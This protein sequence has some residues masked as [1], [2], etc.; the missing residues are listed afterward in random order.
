M[1]PS[2]FNTFVRRLSVYIAGQC[3]MATEELMPKTSKAKIKRPRELKAKDLDYSVD[4][5][6]TGVTST[7]DVDP[8]CTIIG[9][10]RAIDAIKT[11]LNVKSDGYNIFVT[12]LVGTGRTT[13]IKHLLEQ[14]D[15]KQPK[16]Q[17]VCYVN[18]FKN[19]DSPK[20]LTFPAGDGRRF[21]KDMSYL[22]S[23]VRKAVPKIFMSDDYK[24][25][26]SRIVRE[27]EGRQ[28]DLIRG[29][30]EKLNQA[31]F[32]MVQVQSGMGIRNEIQPLIDE[33]PASLDKLE[34]LTHEGKFSASRLDELRRLWDRLRREFD[35]TS[36]ESKKLTAKLEVALEK[37]D[38]GVIAPLV[39][40]KVNLLKKRFPGDR[41]VTYLDDVQEALMSDLDRFRGA[42]PRRGEE[43]APPFR[44]REPFEEFAVNLV[45]DNAETDSVPIIIEMSPSYKNLFGSLERVVDR[46]GYWRT[47][48]TRIF[49]GSL[50]RASGGFLVMNAMDVLTEP[51]V[52][53]HLKRAIRNNN[54]EITG[55]DPFYM[56]AG[57]GIKP[58][59][60]PLNVK[61]V[62]IGEPNIYHLLWRLDED[63]KKV[64][65]IKAEFDSVMPFTKRHVTEYY[66]FTRRLVENE[67]LRPFDIAGMQAVA[68]YGRRLAGRR[69]KL[70]TRFTAI[71]DLIREASYCA[72]QRHSSRAS[73]NDVACALKNRRTRVNLVEDKIQEMIDDNTLMVSTS[74]GAVGQINGL[75]VYNIGNYSFGRPTRITVSTSMGKAGV[76]NIEREAELSGP[77]HNKG[78]LVLSGFLRETFA[79]DKPLVMSASISFEQSYSGVD[80]DSASSTEIYAILSSLAELPLRQD[81]AVTGSVNQK[82]EIQ[83]IGGVNEKVEGFFDVCS[84]RRLT[85]DQGVIIPHQ[86][87]PDLMLRADVIEAVK[88]GQFHIYPIKTIAQGIELLTGVSAGRRRPSG[89]FTKDSV[90]ARVD[91]KLRQMALA[92]QNFGRSTKNDDNG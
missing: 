85:G 27:F 3:E 32:V 46:F 20:V 76:I 54:I 59:P 47:D 86:N 60:I 35:V 15:H 74:G 72:A 79:Q 81:L 8:C 21:K 53:V 38:Y 68:A 31:G 16:L 39:N 23:S 17:D 36:T 42:R 69:N 70:T 71:S 11:G 89:G 83:P 73:A 6:P 37:L 13:T 56:M 49:S 84:S 66:R 40:D 5:K 12:G 25:R 50:L 55:Y 92:L 63:F 51:G 1:V 52:W 48:F 7:D 26:H 2:T 90:L 10:G 18:N 91:E 58:E 14:L 62:L 88:A 34:Q 80:G 65:K 22:I 29:F 61:V 57:S 44:K 87:V 75:S 41:V 67:K 30:E 77:I 9:Q 45:L 82:G 24:D 4:L 43:E 64:F 28:K 78:V 33:E 19:E